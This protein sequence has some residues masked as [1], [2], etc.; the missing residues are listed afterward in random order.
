MCACNLLETY[1][2]Y[3]LWREFT[4]F[5]RFCFSM[6]SG[7]ISIFQANYRISVINH[8][9]FS[10][11]ILSTV[12][13]HENIPNKESVMF[14]QDISIELLRNWK[15]FGFPQLILGYKLLQLKFC[16]IALINGKYI[17]HVGHLLWTAMHHEALMVKVCLYP[18]ICW[19]KF[20]FAEFRITTM[21][22]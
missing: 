1:R 20:T 17:K 2:L 19:G 7:F 8:G 22:S 6:I 3:L 16:G 18:R 15:Y 4:V 14:N 13:N 10:M 11:G 5:I 12:I 9:V 21:L